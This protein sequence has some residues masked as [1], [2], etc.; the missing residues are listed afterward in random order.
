MPPLAPLALATAE[1]VA[2]A[3][4][5]DIGLVMQ[6]GGALG[7]Y[8]HGA[9]QALLDAGCRPV[10][11]SGVSIGAVNTAVLAGARGG[12]MRA[13]IDRLWAAITLPGNPFLP[14]GAQAVMSVF[15]DPAFWT[16][17]ADWYAAP[18]WTNLYDTGPMYRTLDDIVDWDRINLPVP[19]VRM[20][21]TATCV[22]TG[23]NRRFSNYDPGQKAA[24]MAGLLDGAEAAD[25]A[26]NTT[27]KGRTTIAA[28]HVMASGALPPSFPSVAVDGRTYWDGGLFDNTPLRPLVEMLTPDEAESLPIVIVNLFP[29]A[30]PAPRDFAG[31]QTRMM[32][33]QYES[34]FSDEFGGFHNTLRYGSMLAELLK[35]AADNPAVFAGIVQDPQFQRLMLYRAMRNLHV[36]PAEDAFDATGTLDF[37]ARGIERRREAGYAAVQRHFDDEARRGSGTPFGRRG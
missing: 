6:G 35:L 11:I 15:G 16:P 33:I 37:S 4:G 13:S 7:A 32:E 28:R 18:T 23:R 21:V 9:V 1:D 14:R 34:R 36:I 25:L 19:P 8:E 2:M 29:D 5:I 12:D 30:A 22:G 27:I 26:D 10:A 3:D 17:R 31:V 20:A 24:A